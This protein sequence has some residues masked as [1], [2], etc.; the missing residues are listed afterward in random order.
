MR[1][2]CLRLRWMC[3]W[4]ISVA[5]RVGVGCQ[6]SKVDPLIHGLVRTSAGCCCNL[7]FPSRCMQL[8]AG[9]CWPVRQEAIALITNE[10]RRNA[11]AVDVALTAIAAKRSV[12]HKPP[13]SVPDPWL[14][15]VREKVLSYA[16]LEGSEGTAAA[17]VVALTLRLHHP[18]L[19]RHGASGG[20]AKSHRLRSQ[21][22]GSVPTIDGSNGCIV[23]AQVEK[24]FVETAEGRGIRCSGAAGAAGTMHLLVGS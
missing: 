14:T 13:R 15:N 8:A 2:G 11:P 20:A 1:S 10:Q 7:V 12:H 22:S 6:T 17:E 23:F 4:E 5:H 24:E 18:P 3:D 16:D 9:G 21:S 19:I